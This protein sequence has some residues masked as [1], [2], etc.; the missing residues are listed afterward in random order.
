MPKRKTEQEAEAL[1]NEF[2]DSFFPL[3]NW[4]PDA[5]VNILNQFSL[6]KILIEEELFTRDNG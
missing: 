5:L 6:Y 4:S 2:D 3:H 1:M